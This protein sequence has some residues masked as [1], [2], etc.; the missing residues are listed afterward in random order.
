[1]FTGPLALLKWLMQAWV[2]PAEAF[3]EGSCPCRPDLLGTKFDDFDG[4][5]LLRLVLSMVNFIWM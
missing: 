2:S 4:S 5:F 3:W 1:V